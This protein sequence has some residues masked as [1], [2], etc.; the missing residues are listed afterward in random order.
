[1]RSFECG[2]LHP[3]TVSTPLLSG[4][5]EMHAVVSCECQGETRDI[6]KKSTLIAIRPIVSHLYGYW[7][8]SLA[9]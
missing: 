8:V 2:P 1:M 9:V 5:I 7:V 6:E 3:F 4:F